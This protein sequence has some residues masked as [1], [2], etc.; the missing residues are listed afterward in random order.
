MRLRRIE[1]AHFRKLMG[2]V[3]LD[4]LSD[5]LV[6]IS[7]DNEE[8]KSTILAALKAAF[9][10]HHQTGGAV[11]EAMAPHRGGVPEIAVAF[12]VGGQMHRLRKA[13]RRGGVV[14]ETPAQRLQDDA[15]ERRLQE[16]LR[17]PATAGQGKVAARERRPA[18]AVLGR[19]GDD[20]PGLRS[21][22]RRPRAPGGGD[23][24]RDRHYRWGRAVAA[25]AVRGE[26][27][28]GQILYGRTETRDGC[29]QGRNRPAARARG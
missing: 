15:A 4:E 12:E 6:V 7:G 29:A 28:R 22:R 25:P 26:R 5:G 27:T 11:R 21:R 13:F 1:I 3:V 8:G 2:P 18:I 10:E 17:I 16:L 9:F 23:R 14:L 24:G 20:L 19:S